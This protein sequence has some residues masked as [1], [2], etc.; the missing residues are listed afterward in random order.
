MSQVSEMVAA[1]R[2]ARTRLWGNPPKVVAPLKKK[3]A[4]KPIEPPPSPPLPIARPAAD[5]HSIPATMMIVRVQLAVARHFNIE[6]IEALLS[7]ERRFQRI[8]FPRQIA[9]YLAKTIT[10]QSLSVIGR[11]FGGMDHTT[12]MHAVRKVEAL[13]AGDPQMA[14][15]VEDL[16]RKIVGA[17]DQ[18]YGIM[19][20]G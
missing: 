10:H 9:M 20:A 8:V 16:R 7:T 14:Q 19:A 17:P 2:G 15:T 1:Y 6:G 13:M 12:V 18:L 3:S 11:R 4:P 5:L